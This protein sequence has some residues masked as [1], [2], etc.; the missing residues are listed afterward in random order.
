MTSS[1]SDQGHA[2]GTDVILSAH[3]VAKTYQMGR[4]EVNVLKGASVELATG[5]WLSILGSSGSG[6]S[7]LLHLLGGLDQ[8]D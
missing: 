8:A 4:V 5:E 6:K 3:D 7:T 2:T 1:T